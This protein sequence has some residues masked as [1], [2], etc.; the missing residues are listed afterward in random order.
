MYPTGEKTT[1]SIIEELESIRDSLLETYQDQQS[2]PSYANT[3]SPTKEQTMPPNALP[4][5]R[6]LFDDSVVHESK[7]NKPD[8][9]Q[10]ENP[11]LPKHI[12]DR[13]HGDT[14]LQYFEESDLTKD[15]YTRADA[16]KD[17][18]HKNE[19][20]KEH[21]IINEIVE[22][23]LPMMERELRQRL[24]RITEIGTVFFKTPSVEKECKTT[25]QHTKSREKVE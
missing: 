13:L 22:R 5:Q 25:K 11:F 8:I 9:S 16:I 20:L 15:Y 23:Y 1:D 10:S 7:S 19:S 14:H 3:N 18:I 4:G 17:D 12:R 2:V 21:V 6:S 24:A